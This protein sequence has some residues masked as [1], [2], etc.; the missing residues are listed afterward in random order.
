MCFPPG[1][2]PKLLRHAQDDKPYRPLQ[3]EDIQQEGLPEA[4]DPDAYLKSR[5][6]KFYAEVGR[7]AKS[8]MAEDFIRSC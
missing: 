2:L 7:H 4:N 1:I 8:T 5:L 3:L 6:D